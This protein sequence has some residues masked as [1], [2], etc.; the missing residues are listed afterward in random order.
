MRD[1]IARDRRRASNRID[2][3]ARA[4]ENC[5]HTAQQIEVSTD[6]EDAPF[7]QSSSE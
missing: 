2:F 7:R 1:D 6:G 4:L 5:H 3:S